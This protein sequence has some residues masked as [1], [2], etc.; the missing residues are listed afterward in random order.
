MPKLLIKNFGPIKEIDITVEDYMLFIGPQASGKS[1]ISKAIYFFKSL[2]D[3]LLRYLL[4]SIEEDNFEK[5]LGVYGKRIRGKFLEFWGPTYHLNKLYLEYQIDAEK[6][7]RLT[8]KDKYVNPFFSN[9]FQQEFFK[10]LE[11]A[12]NLAFRTK[13]RNPAYM[14]SNELIAFESE[15]RSYLRIIEG[16]INELFEDDRDLYFIP[17]GRSLLATLSDQLQVIQSNKIDYLMRSF[18]DRINNSKSYFNKSLDDLVNDKKKLS[19]QKIDFENVDSAKKKISKILRGEYHYDSNGEKIYYD[20]SRY[21]KLNYASSGQQESVW[22]L[23]LIF[24][25]ILENKK[26]YVVFEEPEAHLYPEAQKEMIELI[27]LLANIEG[28]QVTITTHSPYILSA[29]NNLIYAEIVG[30]QNY[31][32]AKSVIDSR[33]WI[34]PER[35]RAYFVDNGTNEDII[36]KETQLIKTEAIDSA[37]EI[38]NELYSKIFELDL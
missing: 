1:T 16:L 4:D 18:I 22:I 17:A 25:I 32:S 31:D 37:S 20:Q 9:E 7:I 10:I 24:N 19:T 36:D 13:S 6:Y 8:I 38:I 29:I 23:L 12:K 27:S 11:E 33:T 30:G 35:F 5:A 15:K 28:N 3:D 21:V 34:G 2:R 26:V 14:S